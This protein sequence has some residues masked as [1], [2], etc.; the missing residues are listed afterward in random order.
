[1]KS[2]HPCFAVLFA[3]LSVCCAAPALAAEPVTSAQID[4]LVERAM[5]AFDVPGIAVAV[6]KDDKVIHSKGYGVSSL[7]NRQKVDEH[8]DFGIASNSKAFTAAALAILVD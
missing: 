6:I 1:M 4:T 7:K 8:T 5:R 2:R 3:T